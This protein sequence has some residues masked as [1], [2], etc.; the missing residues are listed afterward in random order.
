ML[1]A[2]LWEIGQHFY[3]NLHIM[4]DDFRKKLE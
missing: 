3:Q 4:P 2:K 1:E